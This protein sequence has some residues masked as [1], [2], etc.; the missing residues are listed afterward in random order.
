MALTPYEFNSA[1]KA[2]GELKRTEL[3]RKASFVAMLLNVSGKVLNKS[4]DADDL[5]GTKKPKKRKSLEQVLK[6][7]ERKGLSHA[8]Y[9]KKY[10]E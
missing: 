1:I 9:L 6:E 8:N 2:A 4:V 10:G 7:S 5:L 3:R